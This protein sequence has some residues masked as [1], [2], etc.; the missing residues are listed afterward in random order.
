M[1]PDP[2]YSDQELE[3][4]EAVQGRLH[5]TYARPRD[6]FFASS[7]PDVC[8]SSSRDLQVIVE[9]ADEEEFQEHLWSG[10]EVHSRARRYQNN[11]I[12]FEARGVKCQNR[13]GGQEDIYLDNFGYSVPG[14]LESDLPTAQRKALKVV[15]SSTGARPSTPVLAL[16]SDGLE[17]DG[18]SF[19]DSDVDSFGRKDSSRDLEEVLYDS[20]QNLYDPSI[21]FFRPHLQPSIALDNRRQHFTLED[22][23]DVYD[24]SLPPINLVDEQEQSRGLKSALKG[25]VRSQLSDGSDLSEVTS[26]NPGLDDWHDTLGA[27]SRLGWALILYHAVR[28]NFKPH[29]FAR[30]AFQVVLTPLLL[31]SSSPHT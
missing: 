11:D 31:S 23:D 7:Q 5:P 9:Y 19:N 26:V 13:V 16:R 21:Q 18:G 2:D 17:S 6:D 14:E 12:P 27:T 29:A 8:P 25:S 24:P 3:S 1:L 15:C 28:N 22:E 10:D 20:P 30:L 4:H